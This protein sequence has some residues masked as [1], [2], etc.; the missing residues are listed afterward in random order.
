MLYKDK[1]TYPRIYGLG[2]KPLSHWLRTRLALQKFNTKLWYSTLSLL[3]RD[4]VIFLNYGYATTESSG[5]TLELEAVDEANRYPIQLYNKVASAVDLRG[6]DVL[7]VGSGRGGGAAFIRKYMHLRSMTG[8][9][10]CGKAV[11]FC[12]RRHRHEKLSF[13]RGDAENLPFPAEFFDA[14]VN[15][16]SCHCYTSVTRFLTQVARVLRSGGHVL[17]ADVGPKP[18]IDTLR[19]HITQCGLSIEEEEDITPA[20]S[21]ALL[22]TSEENRRKIQEQVPLGL[23]SI[24]RNFAGIQDTPVFAACGAGEWVYVRFVLK[25]P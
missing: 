18:Y 19:G 3:A 6:K 22:I 10:F 17:F 5:A 20:V 15:L 25:K 1:R 9:D 23:R 13:V 8:V 12:R 11:K 14:V 16:E 24:F 4:E 21:R 2:N 7:E